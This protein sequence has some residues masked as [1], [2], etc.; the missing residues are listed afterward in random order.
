MNLLRKIYGSLNRKYVQNHAKL[1]KGWR[2]HYSK[3]LKIY[4]LLNL[5][6]YIDCLLYEKGK[7]EPEVLKAIKFFIESKK[8]S[9]FIDVGSNIGQMSLFVATHFPHVDILSFEAYYKNY[10]QH[11]ASMLLNNLDYRL[12]NVAISD[13]ENDL[14]LYLPKIQE[15][16]DWGKYNSGMPSISLDGFR[17]EKNSFV[18][19]ARTLDNIAQEFN[20]NTEANYLLMK[21]DVEGAEYLV[22]NGFKNF[23]NSN[24]KIIIVIE[25]LFERDKVLYDKVKDTLLSIDFKMYNIKMDPIPG[26]YKTFTNTDYI[27]IKE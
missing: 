25:M 15:E 23:L 1:L 12:F 8:V 20:L 13:T 19:K 24:N 10:R 17:E 18:V 3:K 5:N 27:F 21:I 4:F 7:F 6:N 9:T 14:T 2:I 11:I 16:Y 22:I 26:E